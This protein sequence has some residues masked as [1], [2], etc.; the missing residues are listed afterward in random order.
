MGLTNTCG[1]FLFGTKMQ[2]VGLFGTASLFGT[3]VFET[4][5]CGDW[6]REN[7]SKPRSH[8]YV[9]SNVY[10]GITPSGLRGLGKMCT[11]KRLRV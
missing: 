1:A 10:V 7:T 2:G 9:H 6:K 8:G 4:N 11:E 3:N 5:L